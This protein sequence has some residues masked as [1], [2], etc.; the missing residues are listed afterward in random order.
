MKWTIRKDPAIGEKRTVRGFAFFPT[1][2]SKTEKVWLQNYELK[3]IYV[4]SSLTLAYS[5]RGYWALYDERL[6][7][8]YGERVFGRNVYPMWLDVNPS[9]PPPPPK[10]ASI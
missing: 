9:P 4:T 10:M 8:Y 7:Q 5:R 2:I 3:Q 1:A 6:D